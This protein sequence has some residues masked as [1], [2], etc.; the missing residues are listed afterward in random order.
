MQLIPRHFTSR[1]L[2]LALIISGLAACGGGGGSSNDGGNNGGGNGGG[3]G[4]TAPIASFVLS[5]ANGPAPLLITAD[6]S[7][8]SDADGSIES[9]SWDFEGIP[10]IGRIAQHTFA[11]VGDFTVTLTVTDNEGATASTTRTVNVTAPASNV[12]LTGTVQILSSSAVDADVNDRLTATV[13]N[14]TFDEAQP[15]PTPVTLGGFANLANTGEST[16]NLFS[17]GDPGDFYRISL[18]GNE[19]IALNIAEAD[20]DLDLYLWDDQRNLIDASMGT[21]ASETLR[22]TTPGDYFIEVAPFAGASNYV[23]NVGQDTTTLNQRAPVRLSDPIAADELIVKMRSQPAGA[24]SVKLA[25]ATLSST[26]YSMQ[27]ASPASDRAQLYRLT[28]RATGL[29]PQ[30][31][32]SSAAKGGMTPLQLSRWHTLMACKEFA[33]RDDVVYAEPNVLVTAHAEPNDTFFGSQWHYPA[34]SLPTAWDT[35]TGDS[36]V[37]VAVIDTGV[38]LDHPDLN[39]NLIAGYDFISDPQRARDGDGIDANPDDPGD[40]GFGGSSSFHGTHVAGTVGAE[41]NNAEGGAGVAW[42]TSIMPLRV[43]GVNGGT[44]FDVQQAVRYAAGL[45]NNSNTVPAR[46]ADI[47]NLSLGSSFSSQAEQE[48]FLAVQQAGVLVIASAGND[49]SSLPSYPA[50]YDGV[51][52]VSATTITNSLASYSNFG[53]TIDIAA[54]GGS[55]VTDIN[56]DGIGDG[57]IST[58]GDDSGANIE[59]GYATLNGTSMAAPHVA[60]VA[61]LMQALH[62]AMTPAEFNN[63]L[64]AGD[65]TDDLGSVGPDDD[66]GY[67]LINAQKAVVA[68]QLMANGQGSDPGPIIT[69]STRTVSFGPFTSQLEVNIQN[70]GTGNPS[71]TNVTSSEPWANTTAPGT[72]DGLGS[73]LINV[74]RSGLADGVYQAALTFSTDANDVEVTLIMQVSSLNLTANA[75]LHY[76]I[77][78]DANNES[79]LPAALVNAT[80][81]EYPFTINDV[82]PGQYRLFAGTDSDD[83]AFLC[84]A[85]EACGAYPTLD[86]P[87]FIAISSNLDNLNFESGFRVNLTSAAETN[88]ESSTTAS[89]AINKQTDESSQD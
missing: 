25:G 81:G 89:I 82:P 83:D 13:S 6:A 23:L 37:I 17:S 3:N 85:G 38:L 7:A 86:A 54:P 2:F 30:G 16:G 64:L 19:L 79:V 35:T 33:A 49:A 88:S 22:V 27:A 11:D 34:I 51:I 44:S 53:P 60:G 50:A 52:S 36:N 56:G 80:N 87:D 57:V 46:R 18:V 62:P 1:L 74:N 12:T 55:N 67:G 43:L 69:A 9:Y 63:A 84:D 21:T 24:K 70:I 8:A 78:V 66:F 28:Q 73:Y 39:D 76:V 5:S 26:H 77:L 58:I 40:G 68:A 15:L 31:V 48:T 20:A 65:L 72:A 4:N 14:N 42:Q 61:A 71:V 45:S 10:A 32:S 29:A 41:S 75:G 47:I 59:F